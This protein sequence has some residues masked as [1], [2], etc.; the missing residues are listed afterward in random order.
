[1]AEWESGIYE[2]EDRARVLVGDGWMDVD[3]DMDI[4]WDER[5]EVEGMGK[6][7]GKGMGVD[8]WIRWIGG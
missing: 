4:P 7:M 5:L 2:S 3:M 1:M 6:G 8:G